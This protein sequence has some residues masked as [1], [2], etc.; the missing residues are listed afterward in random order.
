MAKPLEYRLSIP[1]LGVWHIQYDPTR[2]IWLLAYNPRAR[3]EQWVPSG[4]FTLAESA[5]LAVAQRKTG[6]RGWDGLR[7]ALPADL[8]LKLWKTDESEGIQADAVD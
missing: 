8:D 1:G 6:A 3:G 5:A 2:K 4:E 7:F